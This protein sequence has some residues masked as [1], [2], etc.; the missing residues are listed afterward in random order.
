MGTGWKGFGGGNE[1]R[2]GMWLGIGIGGEGG[3]GDGMEMRVVGLAGGCNRDGKG[4]SMGWDG[5][6]MG[7]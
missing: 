2:E 6:G 5:V 4:D 7:Q 1:D 3:E